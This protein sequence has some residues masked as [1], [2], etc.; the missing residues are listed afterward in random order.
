MLG[1][2]QE[3]RG[4]LFYEFS[5]EDHVPQDH[6]LR[7]IDRFVDLCG[8]RQHLAPLVNF[9]TIWLGGR[10]AGRKVGNFLRI[11]DIQH[12][13]AFDL[14]PIV[15]GFRA[16]RERTSVRGNLA[17]FCPASQGAVT[18]LHLGTGQ[19]ATRASGSV[20]RATAVW[21]F[22]VL[23]ILLII[24]ELGFV[25]L[26]KTGA[27]LLFEV[28][29]H[30]YGRGS[31]V[32]T[33]NLPFDEWT[34]VFGS[35]RLLGAIPDRL[36]HHVHKHEMK[37]ESFGCAKAAKPKPEF[38]RSA[39]RR[40]DL[41][42]ARLGTRQLSPQRACEGAANSQPNC[43]IL[44]RET[45]PFC[46]GIDTGMTTKRPLYVAETDEAGRINCVWY[47]EAKRAAPR[48]IRDPNRHLPRL[49]NADCAGANVQAITNWMTQNANAAAE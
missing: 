11:T 1:P 35:E 9:D 24:G 16:R 40:T 20:I 34:E 4:A 2:K 47:T 3:A 42:P 46:A 14:A 45:D 25:P 23:I 30:R 31:H 18:D 43:P 6:L 44:D 12:G 5:I 28:I 41:R 48:P 32:I 29:F 8:I 37:G 33:F 10:P 15:G 17:V 38:H 39:I 21:R 19:G 26:S 22:G 7:S 13:R 36:T 27:E 49:H